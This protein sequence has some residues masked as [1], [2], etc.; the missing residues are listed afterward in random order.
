MWGKWIPWGDDDVNIDNVSDMSVIFVYSPVLNGES[1]GDNG[2]LEHSSILGWS[3]EIG[4]CVIGGNWSYTMICC[5]V[6]HC[7]AVH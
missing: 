6:L 4:L 2:T 3:N 1:D 7:C 5:L